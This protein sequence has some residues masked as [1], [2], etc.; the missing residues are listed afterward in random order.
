MTISRGIKVVVALVLLS[1]L[2]QAQEQ[3]NKIQ[4]SDLPP[5][6]EKTVVEQVEGQRFVAF[7]KK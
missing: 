1:V 6:V 4:R 5:A 2:A 7:P 3:E